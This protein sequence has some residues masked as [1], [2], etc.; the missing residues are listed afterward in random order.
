MCLCC[1]DDDVVS[2]PKPKVKQT[3]YCFVCHQKCVTS[4][5]Y[6]VRDILTGLCTACT[7]ELDAFLL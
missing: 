5:I 4:N 2:P 1:T 7:T 6:M 3:V